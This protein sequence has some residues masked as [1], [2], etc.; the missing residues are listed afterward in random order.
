[1]SKNIEALAAQAKADQV[2]EMRKAEA[3]GD[4]FAAYWA[5]SASASLAHH[6]KRGAVV[7][8]IVKGRK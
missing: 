2:A 6:A 5:G 7:D 1:M 3:A 8:V 4:G